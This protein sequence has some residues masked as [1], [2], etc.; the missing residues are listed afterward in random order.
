MG[1]VTNSA[2]RIAMALVLLG[3]A[4]SVRAQTPQDL[5]QQLRDDNADRRLEAVQ[6][7][8]PH[9]P[10]VMGALAEM[11]GGEDQRL[12]LCA[13]LAV[14][15]IAYYAARPE[16]AEQR[17]AVAKALGE[18]AVSDKPLY[19]RIFAVQQL[20]LC[21]G[22]ESLPLLWDLLMFQPE[23]HETARAAL[24]RMPGRGPVET[25]ERAVFEVGD[26]EKEVGLLNA[27]AA[28]PS[29]EMYAIGA[30]ALDDRDERVRIAA[31]NL[32]AQVPEPAG[33]DLMRR[34]LQS[35]SAPEKAAARAALIDLGYTLLA[36]G[37]PSAAQSLFLELSR[38]AD[39]GKRAAGIVGLGHT[40][41]PGALARLMPATF[42][43]DPVVLGAVVEALI[44]LPGREATEAIGQALSYTGP[45]QPPPVAL[46]IRV[47]GDRKDPAAIPTLVGVLKGDSPELRLAALRALGKIGV[48]D[49]ETARAI[50]AAAP[51]G[52]DDLLDAAEGALARMSGDDVTQA[53]ATSAGDADPKVRA[54]A[55]RCLGYRTG[56][57]LALNTV[58]RS[59]GD[60]DESVRLAAVR[61]L[62]RLRD[63]DTV[64]ALV[65]LLDPPGPAAD[66]AQQALSR[67][68][69]PV[70]TADLVAAAKDADTPPT[71]RAGILRAL[72]PREDQTLTDLFSTAAADADVVVAVAGLEGLARL[73]DAATASA[74]VARIHDENP[75]VRRAAVRGYLGIAQATEK[76]QGAAALAIYR[77][78]MSMDIDAQEKQTALRGLGRL[79]DVDAL[80]IIEPCLTDL[81]LKAAAAEAAVPIARKLRAAGDQDRAIALC[82]KA[83]E[84]TKD[85]NVLREAARCLREMG[86]DLQLAAQR[87]CLTNWWV[88]GP[89]P[90][91][92]RAT[93]NDFVPVAERLDLAKTVQDG[94]QTL[95]WKY[96]PVDDPLGL[97]DFER[98]VARMDNCGA[99]AYAEVESDRDEDVLLKIGSDDSVFCWLN[100]QQ[101][102]AWDGNRGWGEDQDTVKAHL[103]AGTNTVL[104]KV[105]NGGA[106]WSLSVR[107]T[108]PDG[109]P[110]V[111]KQRTG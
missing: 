56:A 81:R 62:G 78:A 51:G 66:A 29:V 49:V 9:G 46:F 36:G 30:K 77:E 16:G 31:L 4:W 85:R 42:E 92:E 15:R 47:L 97:L 32:L 22:D 95:Q 50:L 68:T 83:V 40:G 69:D 88:L 100:G 67:F 93:R 45:D 25:L 101:V 39:A 111:L 44:A 110:L 98:T 71:A 1:K 99:Y 55:L 17:E 103:K 24:A 65:P 63:A 13:R 34:A 86:V 33:A 61:A 19:T 57:D 90:N 108:D 54:L 84:A 79:A 35:G 21:G 75:D 37:K 12:D 27:L 89:F 109:K 23:M 70:A 76:E 52:S 64:L 5:L 3:A 18:I 87:G 48:G 2:R 80:P 82:R 26:A 14:Q 60:P 59:V 73:Q 106:Q 7:L 104:C 107:I 6:A 105:I 10:E 91:R 11:L 96:A 74:F 38:S 102:H 72:M 43:T 94:D 58:L 41:G 53:I 20:A 28:R 8:A